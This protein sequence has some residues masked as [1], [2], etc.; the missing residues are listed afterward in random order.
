MK[1][2]ID[3]FDTDILATVFVIFWEK[4]LSNPVFESI[5]VWNKLWLLFEFVT[6]L[7][8]PPSIALVLVWFFGHSWEW[9]QA[10]QTYRRIRGDQTKCSGTLLHNIGTTMARHWSDNDDTIDK[11]MFFTI[12]LLI[13]LLCY[14]FRRLSDNYNQSA[15]VKLRSSNLYGILKTSKREFVIIK[16]SWNACYDTFC[17][18]ERIY[19]IS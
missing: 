18:H 4:L 8:L 19:W 6:C 12:V 11:D 1:C 5:R 16:Q 9:C 17:S 13:K 2:P 14:C 3:Y 10:F 7:Q 15:S